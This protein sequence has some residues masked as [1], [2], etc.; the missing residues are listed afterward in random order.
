MYL[1]IFLMNIM[2]CS[3]LLSRSGISLTN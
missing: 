1:K 2:K 3:R